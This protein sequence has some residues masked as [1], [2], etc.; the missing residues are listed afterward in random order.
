MDLGSVTGLLG[1]IIRIVQGIDRPE[2]L[3]NFLEQLGRDHRK[4]G[5]KAAHYEAVGRALVA[6]LKRY[7]GEA[8]TPEVEASWVAAYS[9]AAEHDDRGPPA[10]PPR[11][12]RTG[13][14]PR[15][16]PTRS[17]PETSR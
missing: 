13:G 11:T 5:A 1:A 12:P 9:R 8:W 17:A 3:A 16:F 7:A 2:F 14:W 10:A 15:S 6:A 4:F